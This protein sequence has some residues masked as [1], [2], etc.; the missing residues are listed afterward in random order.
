M[1]TGGGNNESVMGLPV[2]AEDIG[3]TLDNPQFSYAVQSFDRV[4]GAF[5]FFGTVDAVKVAS[6]DAFSPPLT[7]TPPSI[8]LLDDQI[9]VEVTVN[10]DTFGK[11]PT[12]GLL[13]LFPTNG[14]PPQNKQ[15]QFI[16]VLV[17]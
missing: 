15:A 10:A 3:V 7:T 2:R 13:I 14:L 8:S 4:G 11:T 5:D 1:T 12:G 16:P 17:R 6:F 9:E